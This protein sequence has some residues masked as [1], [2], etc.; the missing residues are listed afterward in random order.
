MISRITVVAIPLVEIQVTRQVETAVGGIWA[1]WLVAASLADYHY[2]VEGG[3][4]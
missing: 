3:T 1:L 4:P 2:A